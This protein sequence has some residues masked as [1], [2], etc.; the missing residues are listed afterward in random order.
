MRIN[1]QRFVFRK[2]GKGKKWHIFLKNYGYYALC[3]RGP[4]S[5]VVGA[6]RIEGVCKECEKEYPAVSEFAMVKIFTE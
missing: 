6:G 5:C 4:G 2:I 3:M 1:M